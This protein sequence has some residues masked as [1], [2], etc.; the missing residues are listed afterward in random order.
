MRNSVLFA[1][2]TVLVLNSRLRSQARS[3]GVNRSLTISKNYMG[4][5]RADET[6]I[7]TGA[8]RLI[9]SIQVL[10]GSNS[11]NYSIGSKRN[12]TG[13]RHS[14]CASG[15]FLRCSSKVNGQRERTEPCFQ[16]SI[17]NSSLVL[18]LW[19]PNSRTCRLLPESDH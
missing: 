15:L 2:V 5:L 7:E 4:K 8:K 14:D 1:M 3:P 18:R 19:R 13:C 11:R 6:V 17:P 12:L 16:K 9:G 10:T